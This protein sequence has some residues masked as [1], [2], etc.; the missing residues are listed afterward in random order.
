MALRFLVSVGKGGKLP[1]EKKV[2]L[3]HCNSCLRTF[4]YSPS[5]PLL[6]LKSKLIVSSLPP[7]PPILLVEKADLF[8]KVSSLFFASMVLN[9]L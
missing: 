5:V 3:V 8:C 4:R 7:L 9:S 6:V 1:S 2:N